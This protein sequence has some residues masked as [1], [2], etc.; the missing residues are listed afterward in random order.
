[1]LVKAGLCRAGQKSRTPFFFR[2]GTQIRSC[3]DVILLIRTCT[4]IYKVVNHLRR[5]YVYDNLWLVLIVCCPRI[6]PFIVCIRLFIVCTR[7]FIVRIR[8]FIVC[9]RPFLVRIRLFI[10]RIRLCIFC[11]RV[12]SDCFRLF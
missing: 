9:T 7:P 1:M 5:P 4:S 12:F 8:L 6:R 2:V 11:I 10:F 3:F